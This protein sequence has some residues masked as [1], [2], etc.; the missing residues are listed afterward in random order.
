[1]SVEIKREDYAAQFGPTKGDKI[2]LADTGLIV[3]IED[4]LTTYGD[5]LVFGGGKT[6]S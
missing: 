2:H 4:D 6:Q 5:E 1:M 3:E